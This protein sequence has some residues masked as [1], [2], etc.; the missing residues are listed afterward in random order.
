MT[1]TRQY[2]TMNHVNIEITDTEYLIKLQ[3]ADYDLSFL[4]TLINRLYHIKH[5]IADNHIID[6]SDKPDTQHA[7]D[8][9]DRFDHLADK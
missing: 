3:K 4:Y 6:F 2:D 9:G 1:D 5:V 8:L 7:D